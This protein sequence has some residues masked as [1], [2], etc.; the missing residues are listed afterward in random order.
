MHR[1]CQQVKIDKA[2]RL[3][4]FEAERRISCVA[5]DC[6]RIF[7]VAEGKRPEIDFTRKA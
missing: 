2:P 7:S 3:L 4:S 1:I 5:Q 6:G